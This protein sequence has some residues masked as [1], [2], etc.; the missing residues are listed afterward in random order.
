MQWVMT[1]HVHYDRVAACWMIQ[2]FIDPAAEISFAP[3]R[4]PLEDLPEG[5][6][7]LAFPGARLGPHDANG[8]LFVKVLREYGI[9]DPALELIGEVIAKGIDYVLH[10]YRPDPADRYGQMGVG[11]AAFADGM[12]VLEPSDP[13]RL[14]DS[15]IVWDSIYALF[16]ANKQRLGPRTA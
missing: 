16:K 10:D 8:P 4:T 12:I 5:A 11:L 1:D 14:E 3:S 13:K 9:E 2:R 15:Y 6:I 7:P